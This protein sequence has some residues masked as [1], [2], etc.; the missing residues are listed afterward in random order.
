[1]KKEPMKQKKLNYFFLTM[2]SFCS[3]YPSENAFAFNGYFYSSQGLKAK[4]MS[5]AATAMVGDAF[6]GG[7]NPAAAMFS[8]NVFEV[9]IEQVDTKQVSGRYSSV[10]PVPPGPSDIQTDGR[11]RDTFTPEIGLNRQISADVSLGFSFYRNG[12]IRSYYNNN[13]FFNILVS[14]SNKRPDTL[15]FSLKQDVFA[16]VVA[17]RVGE[18]SSIGFAPLFVSQR[19]NVQGLGAFITE[20]WTRYPLNVT[21]NGTEESSGVG[22]RLG[23]MSRLHDRV[24]F[25]A[26]FSPKISMAAFNDYKGLFTGNA[27]F[28]VPMNYSVGLSIVAN[29]ATM[30]FIDYQHIEYSKIKLLHIPSTVFSKPPGPDVRFGDDNGPGFGW[31]N[32]R[33]WKFGLEWRLREDLA[34]R[35]GFS[36]NNPSVKARDVSM[37]IL[38]PAIT[39]QEQSVGATY[40]INKN[41][42]VSAYYAL[43]KGP[44]IN[45]I[46]AVAG[47]GIRETLKVR[48]QAYGL[49]FSHNF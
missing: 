38:M 7:N 10:E 21:N 43:S 16:P 8:G 39:T 47:S 40:H 32:V 35:T 37:A 41:N 20:N 6:S 13:E 22:Y 29:P 28:D 24:M 45:G 2:L 44:E 19:L 42:S 18:K 3:I 34:L 17:F 48:N 30:L 33:I 1:M 27:E 9:G 5:G 31:K 12:L 15:H 46:S 26:T 49:L 25:G 23:F 11:Q 4:S 14:D 36:S